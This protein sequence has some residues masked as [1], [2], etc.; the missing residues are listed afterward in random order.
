MNSFD[1]INESSKIETASWALWNKNGLNNI[2][3]FNNNIDKLHSKV[4]ILGLNRSGQN[5]DFLFVPFQNFHSSKHQGDKR[6]EKFIQEDNLKNII[7]CYM[8]DLSFK[9]ETDS[10][11]VTITNDDIQNLLNQINK[12]GK[13]ELKRTIICLGD[14]SF[15]SLC[16]GLNINSLKIK[17]ENNLR[18]INKMVNNE[19]WSIYRV[20]CHGNYG[21]YLHKSTIELKEQ[22]TIINNEINNENN[23]TF[24]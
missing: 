17:E 10:T 5:E 1:Y 11:K 24:V 2:E 6:L 8:T 13:K 23:N 4:I 9:I 3:F 7:G 16:Q 22:L 21:K 12:I 19:N 20:W 18:K 15:D 14:K